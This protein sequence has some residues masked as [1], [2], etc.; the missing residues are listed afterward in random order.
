[1]RFSYSSGKGITS[2][3]KAKADEDQEGVYVCTQLETGAWQ[4]Y[5]S[6]SDMNVKRV[7]VSVTEGETSEVTVI[8][9]P[10]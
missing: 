3:L 5:V 2:T 6:R 7:A 10:K 4:V 8:L 1:M 9:M